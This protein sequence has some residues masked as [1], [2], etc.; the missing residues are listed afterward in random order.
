MKLYILRH[1]QA[2]IFAASDAVRQL[3]PAGREEV[4]RVI[5]KSADSLAEIEKIWVSPLLRAQQTADLALELLN[6]VPR[7]TSDLL[8]PES[9][10]VDVLNRLSNEL[11][12]GHGASY[13]LVSHQPLVGELVNGICGKPNGYYP[14]D[15]GALASL[16]LDV[17]A[18]GCGHLRWLR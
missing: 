12:T 6:E 13:L 10:P 5:R 7:E 14:M 1:G 18:L 8:L 4:R 9:T 3:T 15:T 11:P 17:P 16:E 2:E